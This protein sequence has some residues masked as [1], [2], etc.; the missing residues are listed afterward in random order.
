MSKRKA[1][2]K[3]EPKEIVR[4]NLKSR[5][6]TPVTITLTDGVEFLISPRGEA[7][8]VDVSLIGELPIG[9]RKIPCPK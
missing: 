3:E 1:I 7:R 6:D 4:V 9:I 5:R 8:K 2:E